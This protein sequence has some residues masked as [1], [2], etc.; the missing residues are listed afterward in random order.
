[1]LEINKILVSTDEEADK[2][3]EEAET[4]GTPE[5]EEPAEEEETETGDEAEDAE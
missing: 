2:A 5:V 3:P 1:M 4:E